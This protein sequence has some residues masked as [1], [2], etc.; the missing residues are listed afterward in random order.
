M[1]SSDESKEDSLQAKKHLEIE[2]FIEAMMG[3]VC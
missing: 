2:P 1:E 3:G